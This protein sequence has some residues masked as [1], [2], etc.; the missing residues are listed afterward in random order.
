MRATAMVLAALATLTACGALTEQ[1]APYWWEG[2]WTAVRGDGAPLPVTMLVGVTTATTRLDALL[3]TLSTYGGERGIVDE[4]ATR[5]VATGATTQVGCYRFYTLTATA[6][7]VELRDIGSPSCA[8]S[9]P[10][11]TL[12]FTRKADSLVVQWRGA[13]VRLVRVP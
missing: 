12:V 4:K 2:Q 7:T 9:V 5:T 1:R 10:I 8:E 13:D 11:G 3:V 6:A